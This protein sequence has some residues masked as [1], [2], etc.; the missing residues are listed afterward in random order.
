[1]VMRKAL[2]TFRPPERHGSA[3]TADRGSAPA[4]YLALRPADIDRSAEIWLYRPQ[5]AR[6]RRRS[7]TQE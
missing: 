7:K 2:T 4:E 1:M 5:D 6:R 3:A